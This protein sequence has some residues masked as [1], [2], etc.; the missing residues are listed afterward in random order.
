MERSKVAI[1]I[2]C[3]I[4]LGCANLGRRA[5]SRGIDEVSFIIQ[6]T[7]SDGTYHYNEYNYFSDGRIEIHQKDTLNGTVTREFHR[8]GTISAGEFEKF[9][10]IIFKNELLSK[11]ENAL[12]NSRQILRIVSDKG[13]KMLDID[14][15]ED[16][17]RELSL[18]ISGAKVTLEPTK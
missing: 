7:G 6:G 17:A 14:R 12:P 15:T 11:T 3:L 4:A 8:G 2:I 1:L 9:V 13:T 18:A 10:D 5:N 16:G